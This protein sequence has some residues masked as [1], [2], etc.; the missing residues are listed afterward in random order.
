[1]IYRKILKD[2]SPT[3]NPDEELGDLA[4]AEEAVREKMDMRGSII[5][6]LEQDLKRESSRSLLSYFQ[7]GG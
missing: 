6:Q 5:D 3:L 7:T 4:A 1:M 2:V